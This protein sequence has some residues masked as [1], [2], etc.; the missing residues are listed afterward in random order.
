MTTV[1]EETVDMTVAGTMIVAEDTRKTPKRS[2]DVGRQSQPGFEARSVHVRPIDPSVMTL[3][4]KLRVARFAIGCRCFFVFALQDSLLGSC[5]RSG[6]IIRERPSYVAGD[7]DSFCPQVEFLMK[8]VLHFKRVPVTH[9]KMNVNPK[10]ST[11][12][13]CPSRTCSRT[14]ALCDPVLCTVPYHFS[15]PLY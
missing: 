15:F 14:A 12:R 3:L 1:A 7:D 6:R 13:Y 5:A 8:T 9:H 2:I 4:L 11:S 10:T